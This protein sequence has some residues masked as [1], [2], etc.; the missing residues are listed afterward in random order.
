VL[1]LLE[2]LKKVETHGKMGQLLPEVV[3]DSQVNSS[4][5][6]ILVDSLPSMWKIDEIIGKK[7]SELD[8]APALDMLTSY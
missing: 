2:A 8:S 1:Q 6:L 5:K 4:L 3:F 7:M